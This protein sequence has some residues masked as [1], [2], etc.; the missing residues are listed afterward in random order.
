[1]VDAERG[2]LHS[3]TALVDCEPCDAVE[4]RNIVLNVEVDGTTLAP[5]IPRPQGLRPH[6]RSSETAVGASRGP[7]PA[8]GAR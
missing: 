2:F 4:L 6:A 8:S 5:D 1:V 7:G 3:D